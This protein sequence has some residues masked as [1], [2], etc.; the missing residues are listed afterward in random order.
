LNDLDQYKVEHKRLGIDEEVLA[1]EW[2]S[3]SFEPVILAIPKELTGK[4]EQAEIYHQV[5]EHRWYMSEER[6]RDV[7]MAEAVQHYVTNVL[8]KHRD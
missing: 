5:L 6:D 4:L 3:H 8:S 1:H 7:P 2:L